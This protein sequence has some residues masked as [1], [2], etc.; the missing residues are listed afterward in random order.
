MHDIVFFKILWVRLS[1]LLKYLLWEKYCNY[2]LTTTQGDRFASC[3]NIFSRSQTSSLP[4]LA[5]PACSK[6]RHFCFKS[7]H[8][9]SRYKH[10]CFRLSTNLLLDKI[11]IGIEWILRFQNG[12]NKAL[13]A[14]SVW[15]TLELKIICEQEGGGVSIVFRYLSVTESSWQ[16]DVT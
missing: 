9:H 2:P 3:E 6:L 12:C 4:P 16:C 7:H 1:L 11:N 5:P 13:S 10:F 14:L 8:S 15:L